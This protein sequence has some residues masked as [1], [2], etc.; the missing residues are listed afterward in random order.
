MAKCLSVS[1]WVVW[2]R[3]TVASFSPVS[4][5]ATRVIVGSSSPYGLKSSGLSA[6]IS[7]PRSSRRSVTNWLR[8][9]VLSVPSDLLSISHAFSSPRESVNPAPP[10]RATT[11]WVIFPSGMLTTALS[12]KS[13][14]D[15]LRSFSRPARTRYNVSPLSRLR[16]RCVVPASTLFS[17]PTDSVRFVSSPRWSETVS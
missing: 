3:K 14:T 11:T 5:V 1:S 2:P 17:S 7:N 15:L 12:R 16:K 4:S 13:V 8:V 10:W 6:A 9:A